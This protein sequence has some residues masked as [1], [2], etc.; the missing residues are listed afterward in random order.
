MEAKVVPTE[1][2]RAALAAVEA[3]NAEAGI[4]F[5]TD[6][7][8]SRKVRVAYEVPASDGPAISYPMAV[9][10]EAKEPEAAKRFLEHLDSE[11]A[12]RVFNKFGFIV[13]N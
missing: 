13:R 7:A 2:V 9:M 11:E 1:N 10:R 4:V 5:K 12:G 3:G 6:A 8:T